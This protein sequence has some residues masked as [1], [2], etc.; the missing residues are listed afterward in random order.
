MVAASILKRW[1]FR[2]AFA[3][4]RD[5]VVFAVAAAVGSLVAAT[6]GPL[7][8]IAGGLTPVANFADVALTWWQGDLM[9][10]LVFGPALLVYLDRKSLR[11]AHGKL[12]EFGILLAVTF[13]ASI[14]IFAS[15][16]SGPVSLPFL[17]FP[18]LVWAAIRFTQVGVV[19]ATMLTI[20]VALWG[21]INGLG[22]FVRLG[23]IAEELFEVQVYACVLMATSMI[24]ATAIT[25][26][27]AAEEALMDQARELGRLDSELKEANKRITNI[28]EGIL[29][30]ANHRRRNDGE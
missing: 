22:P 24:M 29:H 7:C 26:R 2:K 5:G 20:I 15:R 10:L 19:S 16:A 25:E 30:N 12:T 18:L 8:L 23:G 4:P 27:L 9:G 1:H 28:L 6:I 11:I 17:L 14:A 3:V 13:A 21:T